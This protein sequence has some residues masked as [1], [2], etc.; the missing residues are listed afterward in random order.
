[1]FEILEN[2]RETAFLDPDLIIRSAGVKAR[3][4]EQDPFESGPREV[5]N[6]GHTIGHAVEKLSRY[7]VGH[8]KAVSIG[9]VAAARISHEMGFCDSKISHRLEAL[10][11]RNEL[12]V[13]SNLDPDRIISAMA[14]DKKSVEGKARFV[15]IKDIGAVEHGC[16][17]A[18]EIVRK[19]LYEMKSG[20]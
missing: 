10:L 3:V 7:S 14:A 2:S 1:L 15:L 17:V 9:M 5:L 8:G 4:V 18:P 13:R 16:E 19:V 20:A 11:A 6:L 12:P